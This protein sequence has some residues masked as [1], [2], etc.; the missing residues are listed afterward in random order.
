MM[1]FQNRPYASYK[2]RTRLHALGALVSIL[3]NTNQTCGAFNAFEVACPIGFSTPLHIHYAEDVAIYVLEGTLTLFWQE[4][5]K[6]GQAG[7]Y[8]FQP[9][10]TPHGFRVEGKSPVRILYLTT[11]AGFDGFL[12]EHATEQFFQCVRDAA[13]YKIEILTALPE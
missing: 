12:I 13:R 6:Q 2:D 5:K 1:L 11:P 9:R 4:E 10:G 3:A 7:S 8:F